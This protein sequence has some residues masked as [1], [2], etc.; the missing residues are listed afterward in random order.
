MTGVTIAIPADPAYVSL[1][2]STTAHIA[3]RSQFTLEE[4]EDLRMAVS[5][6][7]T[8][9]LSLTDVISC[10]FESE[11]DA[12]SIICS[13]STS[14]PLEDIDELPWVLLEALVTTASTTSLDGRVEICLRKERGLQKS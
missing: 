8:L 10:T 13:A 14:K 3:S 5:E 9:L 1:L 4:I 2:R 11:P 12:V 6:A 7:A